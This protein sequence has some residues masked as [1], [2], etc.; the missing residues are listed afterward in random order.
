M[1]YIVQS[2]PLAKLE[3]KGK[4]DLMFPL[5]DQ[6]TYHTHHIIFTVYETKRDGR[7]SH[8]KTTAIAT[9]KLPMTQELQVSYNAG[10]ANP[11]LG[12]IN[13]S[14]IKAAE[15]GAGAIAEISKNT[16]E[17]N[18]TL[19]LDIVDKMVADPGSILTSAGNSVANAGGAVLNQL[20]P[21]GGVL[22]QS[23]MNTFGVARNPHKA[24]LFEGTDFRSHTFSFRFSP[25]K[26]SESD[27]IRNIIAL[28]K[29]HMHPGYAGGTYA[30]VDLS[31]GNHFF[32]TPEFFRIQLSNKGK[33]T[34]SD[35]QICV[36]KGMTVNYQPS[37]YPAYARVDGSD[38]APMEVIMNLEF[39]ETAIITKEVLGN[40][41][42]EDPKLKTQMPKLKEFNVNPG[43]AATG[44]TNTKAG[45]E[46]IA[47]GTGLAARN[48][49]RQLLGR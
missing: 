35:Y 39:Q 10:Y 7:N 16:L 34:V 9:I 11:D 40:P 49:Q 36:L 38:P 48:A 28:F 23:A 45:L 46:K 17:Q 30:G 42:T 5:E 18:K 19:I 21:A 31:S 47:A 37:N 25:V 12:G 13:A 20:A 3:A 43:G 27:A 32:S 6:P 1:A 44:L 15:S 24:T 26:A 8:D 4:V 29:Y 2:S 14:L 41:Y 22:V 33:Y